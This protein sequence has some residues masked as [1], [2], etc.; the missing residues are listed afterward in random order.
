MGQREKGGRKRQKVLSAS[1][2]W[3]LIK[4]EKVDD[5]Q[6]LSQIVSIDVKDLGAPRL[7]NSMRKRHFPQGAF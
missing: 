2:F 1:A 6:L 5:S 4:T 7:P 3:H